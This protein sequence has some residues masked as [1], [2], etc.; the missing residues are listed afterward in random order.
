MAWVRA[1]ENPGP[2]FTDHCTALLN[3][4]SGVGDNNRDMLSHKPYND[5]MNF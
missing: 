2:F 5:L 3:I 4:A 1:V